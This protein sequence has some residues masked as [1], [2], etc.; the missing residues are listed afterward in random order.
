[1]IDQNFIDQ[2]NEN[3]G[4]EPRFIELV[5][6]DYLLEKKEEEYLAEGWRVLIEKGK[7]PARFYFTWNPPHYES[8]WYW[9]DHRGLTESNSLRFIG[10]PFDPQKEFKSYYEAMNAAAIAYVRY[11]YDP[12]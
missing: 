10:D 9:D 11:T 4:K 2:I 12:V 7:K 6:A 1:M 3:A 5:Y 8:R